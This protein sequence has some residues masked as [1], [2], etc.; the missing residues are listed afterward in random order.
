LRTD[1]I[2][3]VQDAADNAMLTVLPTIAVRA[4]FVGA[5]VLSGAK[6]PFHRNGRRLSFQSRAARRNGFRCYGEPEQRAIIIGEQE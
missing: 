2:S 1:A 5:K 6:R 4:L 3:W